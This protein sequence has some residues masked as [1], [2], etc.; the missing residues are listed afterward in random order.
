MR[1]RMDT[2]ASQPHVVTI[3]MLWLL[4]RPFVCCVCRSPLGLV[5]ALGHTYVGVLTLCWCPVQ[6]LAR[7][8]E[9]NYGSGKKVLHIIKKLNMTL[10]TGKIYGLLGPSGCGKT[11]F[12]KCVLGLLEVH[13]D[14]PGY[15]CACLMSCSM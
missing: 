7:D 5:T 1:T 9:R 11:T 2:R 4:R 3:C 12:L 13:I 10:E 8:L 15:A 6:V 14:R